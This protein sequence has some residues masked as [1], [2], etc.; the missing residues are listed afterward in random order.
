MMKSKRSFAISLSLHVLLL[1]VCCF[2]IE[3]KE[4]VPPLGDAKNHVVKSFLYTENEAAVQLAKKTEKAVKQPLISFPKK[5]PLHQQASA[6]SSI[7]Q[8]ATSQA[9]TTAASS[10]GAPSSELLALLHEAIQRQQQYPNAAMQMER[11]G[12]VTLRFTLHRDGHV[13]ELRVE[14]SSGTQSLDEAALAAIDKAAPFQQIERYLKQPAVYRLDVIF[15][16]T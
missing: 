15:S 8:K 4:K 6:V 11:E 13:S 3:W 16:L 2:F 1:L 12:T 9:K 10:A 7:K 14:K 5:M